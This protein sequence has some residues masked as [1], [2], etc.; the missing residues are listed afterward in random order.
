MLTLWQN[1]C[2]RDGKM[3]IF[4]IGHTL[5]KTLQPLTQPINPL[6]WTLHAAISKFDVI[7]IF[8]KIVYCFLELGD[9]KRP[10]WWH[11]ALKQKT[12]SLTSIY[13]L[14]QPN[15]VHLISQLKHYHLLNQEKYR[16][17]KVLFHGLIFQLKLCQ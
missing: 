2:H 14:A 17:I 5:F 1:D 8:S 3:S 16:W 6:T 10:L 12:F 13:V 4:C 15:P 11:D 7:Y 9:S